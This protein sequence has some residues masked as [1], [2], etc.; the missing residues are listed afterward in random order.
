METVLLKSEKQS[1]E[2]QKMISSLLL[3]LEMCLGTS[4]K[5]MEK[6]K[7]SKRTKKGIQLARLKGCYTSKAPLGYVNVRVNSNSTLKFN[8]YSTI[9]KKAYT[10]IVNENQ[11]INSV[12]KMLKIKG[13]KK[14]SKEL[15]SLLSNRVYLG[16]IFVPAFKDEV[17]KYVKGLHRPLVS[18]YLFFKAN[19]LLDSQNQ[20]PINID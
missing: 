9:V 3:E 10:M 20:F 6:Q 8:R 12:R 11:T 14:S 5:Q 4:L 15:K 16:E 17:E 1:T 2:E 13:V 18:E 19:N 7:I